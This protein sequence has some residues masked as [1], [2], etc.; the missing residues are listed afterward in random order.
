MVKLELSSSGKIYEVLI[1][2]YGYGFQKVRGFRTYDAA[3]VYAEKLA[4]KE[5][6]ELIDLVPTSTPP[7]ELE[8]TSEEKL[9]Q[10]LTGKSLDELRE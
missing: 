1:D 4:D 7:I 2:K 10:I 8:G 9:M 5:S 3:R 6:L